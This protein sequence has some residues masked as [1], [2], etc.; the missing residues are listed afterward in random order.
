MNRNS[1][2]LIRIIH[3]RSSE[4]SAALQLPRRHFLLPLLEQT[5]LT[6]ADIRD[7]NFFRYAHSYSPEL[8]L[9]VAQHTYNVIEMLTGVHVGSFTGA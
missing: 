9:L 2:I 5:N 6:K 4:F 1:K 3:I 8:R 7:K